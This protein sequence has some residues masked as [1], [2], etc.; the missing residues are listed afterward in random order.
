MAIQGKQPHF[1]LFPFMAQGHM[2]P[3]IDIA[4]LLSKR[5]V[6][7]TLL[8]TPHN[9]N[10]FKT[11]ISRAIDSCLSIQFV[12]INF[13]LLKQGSQKVPRILIWCLRLMMRLS[14]SRLLQC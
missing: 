12:N 5:G 10:R 2:I 7:V 6:L 1:V 13:L 11:V 4:R 3:R 9:Q 8:I 14:F